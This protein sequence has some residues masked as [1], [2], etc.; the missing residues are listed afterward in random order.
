MKRKRIFFIVF[1]SLLFVLPEF[2]P[3][4]SSFQRAFSSLPDSD[5]IIV[6]NSGGWGDTLWQNAKDFAPIVRGVQG[7]LNSLG[8]S[9]MVVPYVRTGGGFAR[10][11]NG[12]K[13]G[14]G[15]YSRQAE[16]V[17][18]EIDSF[19]QSYPQKRVIMAGLSNG[20]SF[21][22]AVMFKLPPEI[23][24]RVCA[25]EVGPPF[26][27][28][29]KNESD[30]LFIKNKND[31]LAKGN[32]LELLSTFLSAPFK[33]TFSHLRGKHLTYSKA[34]FVPGHRYSWDSPQVGLKIKEFLRKKF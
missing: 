31:A 28:K 33:W 3:A 20:A 24:G 13:E 1:I 9:S 12:L 26:W 32:V 18:K 7:E 10:K 2:L 22:N 14:L 30:I 16:L 11:L 27:V 29:E 17:A 23:R 5:V 6:S 19:L 34:L 8:F 25:I 4:N 15:I 21:V